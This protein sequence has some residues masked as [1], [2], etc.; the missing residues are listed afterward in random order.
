MADT[1]FPDAVSLDGLT[2]TQNI[3]KSPSL[4]TGELCRLEWLE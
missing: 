3:T 4:E 1:N 2:A